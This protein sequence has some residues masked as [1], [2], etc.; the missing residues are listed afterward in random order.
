MKIRALTTISLVGVASALTLS[1]PA[2]SQLSSATLSPLFAVL[3]GGNEVDAAGQANAG[4]PDGIGSATVNIVPTLPPTPGSLARVCFGLNV[5]KIDKPTAVH[6]HRG[7][8][9]VN[10]AVVIPFA[11][12][13]VNGAPGFSSGCVNLA[14]NPANIALLTELQGIP[15]NFYVNVHTLA[16]PNG[17][18]RGQLF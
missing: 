3:T 6:I 7:P 4:D 1:T 16:F 12:I 8:A 5:S 18:L 14:N 15:K 13:P 10:G 9:G 2:S 17:A 11:S